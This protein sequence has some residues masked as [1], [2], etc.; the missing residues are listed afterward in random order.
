MS[1]KTRTRSMIASRHGGF[2]ASRIARLCEQYLNAYNNIANWDI[3]TNGELRALRT[4]LAQLGGDVIDVGAN[5]GQWA[6]EVIPFLNGRRIFSF[7]PIPAI[8]AQ[9]QR[10]L[11]GLPQA[12]PVNLGLGSRAQE[13]EFN[14][15]PAVSTISSAYPLIYDEPGGETV[16]CRVVT[17]DE[18]VE[19]NDIERISVL[20]IDVEGMEADC[21]AGFER[22]F[23]RGAVAAVQFEHGPSHVHSGHT[24]KHFI[25]WFGQR[26]FRVFAV[27]PN[28]LRPVEYDL[29]RETYAGQNFFALHGDHGGLAGL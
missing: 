8:F 15:S 2:L 7:E 17:G 20:K 5:E 10:N 3:A 11:A 16:K 12:I 6:R 1:L 28:A 21:L 18:F 14:F 19:G 25:D 13:L 22:T 4:L 23:A 27:F 29:H 9:L 26:D 24:L